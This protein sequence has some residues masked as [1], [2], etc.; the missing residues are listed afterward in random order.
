VSGTTTAGNG[1]PESLSDEALDI[2]ENIALVWPTEA[3]ANAAA[4]ASGLGTCLGPD[5]SRRKL[6]FAQIVVVVGRDTEPDTEAEAI[7]QRC[8][9]LGMESVKRYTLPGLGSTYPDMHEWCSHQSLVNTL[10][11][12]HAGGYRD[13]VGFVGKPAQVSPDFTDDPHPL[14]V[15]LIPVDRLDPAMIPSRLRPW[16]TDIATR[17]GFPLEYPAA[18]AIVGLSGLI[19]RRVAI[20]PK[21]H[22]D[23]LVVPNLW[24]AAIGPPGIQKSPAVEEALR[25]LKRLAAEATEKHKEELGDW[26]AR[27]LVALAKRDAAKKALRNAAHKKQP[28]DEL[29]D[30]ARN[31]MA[32]EG[33]EAPT[34]KRY[35]VS[36]STVEM[37]GV[38]L[39]ANPTGLTIF[40]DELTGFLRTL[41]REGHQSDRAFYLESWQGHGSYTFDRIGRGTLHIPS[42]CLAIFGTIQPGPLARYLRGSISGEEADGFIPRFQVLVYPDPPSTFINIDRYPETEAKNLAYTIFQELN[43]LQPAAMGCSVDEDRGI[44]YLQFSSEA[45][46]FFD[47]Y[48]TE[49]ENRLRSRK[50]ST[51]MEAHLTKYRS[52]MPSLALIFH[53]VESVGSERLQPVS[54]RS[55]MCAAAWCQFLESHA[56]RVYQMAMDGNID[57]AVTLAERIKESLPNPFTIRD[58]QRKGWSGL[59]SNDEV[60]RAIG[61]LEDRNWVKVVEV[62]SDDPRGRGR[63]KE[64]VW[65]N[66]K[67]LGQGKRA[68]A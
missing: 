5:V 16:L 3:D 68:D 35:L 32:G 44:P 23:W 19:G 17:G 31:A 48:R 21:R 9:E 46:D 24:G 59:D 54:L 15:D 10:E 45:Q 20:R 63:P 2:L 33:E 49:L 41:E 38:L 30:L 56:R 13:F 60:R 51:V 6:S 65:V 57:C 64:T 40:R 18:A 61:I 42:V 22:D 43:R 66:P 50:L 53:L 36:D 14:T 62:P 52:L 29:A 37:L 58:V 7:A 27:E 39:E 28:D 55:A 67:L 4:F 25:P 26:N 47:E 11:I 1:Q 34:E 8:V 12:V